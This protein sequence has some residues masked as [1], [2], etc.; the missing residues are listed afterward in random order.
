VFAPHELRYRM[1]TIPRGHDR[2]G[3][4]EVSGWQTSE[5]GG[6]ENLRVTQTTGN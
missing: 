6:Q 2:N 3:R 5:D 4:E 1:G